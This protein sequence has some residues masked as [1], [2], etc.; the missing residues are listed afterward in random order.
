[1]FQPEKRMKLDGFVRNLHVID[2]HALD[3]K[4]LTGIYDQIQSQEFWP[5]S[6]HVTQVCTFMT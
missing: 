3:N 2:G 5:G 6:D 4:M 1:M